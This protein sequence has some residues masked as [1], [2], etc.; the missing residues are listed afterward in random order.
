MPVTTP[1]PSHVWGYIT[2]VDP[3]TGQK[4]LPTD[5]DYDPPVVKGYPEAIYIV[6]QS[7]DGLRS[8]NVVFRNSDFLLTSRLGTTA[9]IYSVH[10][11]QDFGA[12]DP[13][14]GNGNFIRYNPDQWRF[15]IVRMDDYNFRDP[16]GTHTVYYGS[17]LVR[18]NLVPLQHSGNFP[19]LPDLRFR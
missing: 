5:F 13:V 7:L 10:L 12:G 9:Y 15:D 14:G 16:S 18:Y 19:D 17:E 2:F 3:R 11:I 1:E 4:H 8:T 6:F